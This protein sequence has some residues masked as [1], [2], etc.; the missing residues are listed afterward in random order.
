LIV[1]VPTMEAFIVENGP[2]QAASAVMW[3]ALAAALVVYGL[4]SGLPALILAVL[5]AIAGLREMD[6]HVIFTSGSFTKT[7]YWIDGSI[8]LSEKAWAGLALL[9]I[10]G[11]LAYG[12]RRY[13]AK[14]WQLLKSGDAAAWSLL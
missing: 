4:Q 7:S 13:S 11:L 8:P 12:L 9:A 2:V 10:V 1:P 14:L 5:A 3:F 6:G